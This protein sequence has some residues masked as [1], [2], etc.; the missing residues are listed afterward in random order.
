ML[1]SQAGLASR[2][3]AWVRGCG[4]GPWGLRV[5]NCSVPPE[6][7]RPLP[8]ACLI[9]RVRPARMSS[10]QSY[11]TQC[12]HSSPGSSHAAETELPP[13]L[14]AGWLCSL[15]KRHDSST[16]LQGTSPSPCAGYALRPCRDSHPRARCLDRGDGLPSG[17]AAGSLVVQQT[18]ACTEEHKGALGA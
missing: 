6:E 18:T 15:Y 5:C 12:T 3:N 14:H 2:G 4:C 7:R 1:G 13:D 10:Q 9:K 8:G 17:W 11:G 16:L